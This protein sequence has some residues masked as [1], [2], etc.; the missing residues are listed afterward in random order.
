MMAGSGRHRGNI[1]MKP[2][3]LVLSCALLAAV[4]AYGQPDDFVRRRDA[5]ASRHESIGF[6][7]SFAD[8]RRTFRIGETIELR[9]TFHRYDVSPYNY[10][11]CNSLGLADAV[12]DHADGTADP[13]ADLW[14]NGV[15]VL[16]S[17]C[18][19]LSGMSGGVA[20]GEPP[21]PVEFTVYLNQGVR[22]DRPGRYRSYVRSGHR[23]FERV[24][25]RLR[26]MLISNIL[27]LEIGDR[28]RDWERPSSVI[29]RR[30][31]PRDRR[32]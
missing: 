32:G 12:L 7:V 28:D 21:R 26:P 9:F 24:T 5:E 31:W 19:V 1:P 13:Q 11:H 2:S 15:V 17:G 29:F 10:E 25:W 4:E 22:F 8:N 27:E 18:G 20:P 3:A 23:I 14:N 16:G 30:V 6:S